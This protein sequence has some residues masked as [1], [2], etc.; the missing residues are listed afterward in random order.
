MKLT[1]DVNQNP[2]LKKNLLYAFQQL[3]AIMAA[4]PVGWTNMWIAILG[5]VGVLIICILNAMRAM[6][7][8]KAT[9]HGR[10]VCCCCHEHEHHHDDDGCCCCHEHRHDHHEHDGECHCHHEDKE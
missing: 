1:Y 5:D 4:T 7:S 9:S 8:R 2:P 10:E 3:L 6:G